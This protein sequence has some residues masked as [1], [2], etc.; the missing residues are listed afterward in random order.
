MRIGQ[1]AEETRDEAAETISQIFGPRLCGYWVDIGVDEPN[2]V[3]VTHVPSLE[4]AKLYAEAKR[5]NPKEWR[6]TIAF[7]WDT[8]DENPNYKDVVKIHFKDFVE[9]R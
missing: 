7:N 2:S 4:T 9:G 5:R 1:H 8:I 6:V 3:L